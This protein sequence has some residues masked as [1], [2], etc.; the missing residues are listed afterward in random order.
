MANRKRYY[1]L[2]EVGFIGTV[3]NRTP[4]EIFSDAKKTTEYIINSQMKSSS[5]TGE[6]SDQNN[7]RQRT[8]A[9]NTQP[10]AGPIKKRIRVTRPK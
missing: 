10:P 4:V 5:A 3:V 7:L 8:K 2:D 9:T 6:R 1:S